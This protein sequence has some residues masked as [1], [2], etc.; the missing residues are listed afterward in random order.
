MPSIDWQ[1]AAAI[2]TVVSTLAI[3][4]S[5]VVVMLQLRQAARERYFSITAHLFEI[6][7][8]A[9]FQHDQLFLLHMLSCA[10]WDEF[11]RLGRG[12]RAEVAIHRVGGYYDR[13][14][15]LVRHDLIDKQDILPTIGGYAVAVWH[16]IEPLVKEMRLRENALL[17]ENYE[18]LLPE[19]HECYVP[20]IAPLTKMPGASVVEHP[21]PDH[22]VFD[23]SVLDHP[24]RDERILAR[25]N[26]DQTMQACPVKPAPAYAS[27]PREPSAALIQTSSV[28]IEATEGSKTEMAIWNSK[29]GGSWQTASDL[30]LPDS[31]GIAHALSE[32]T[33]S[34]T[35]VL[36]YARGAWCPFCL[37]QLSD[38]A[39]RYSEF[40]R[41]GVEVVALSPET[42]RKA[43]RMR[44]GL[45]LPFTVLSDVN[46]N[47]ARVFG[48]MDHEKP[49]VP[50]P[51]TLVLDS[52]GSVLL[53]TLNQGAKCLFAR[54]TLE[55][56]R[57]LKQG[58]SEA[59]ATLPAPELASPKP[60]RLF[61]Q[62][63]ANMA[64]GLFSR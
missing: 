47:A 49:G 34:G 54:D 12:E 41:S 29:G 30:S 46:F 42:P 26:G 39:E 61:A 64:A 60:G 15:N 48:L 21:V 7:Q 24:V 22:P 13:V 18:S 55:Y 38:Y 2:A 59:A 28:T 51:A 40:K 52:R 3:I 19:C 43:R 10:T 8:S 20:G 56:A 25:H 4:A 57:A 63:F 6:W 45:K 32:F 36:V 35:A 37:R 50:T 9:D 16:R 1:V 11:C 58:D 14:G 53:S 5:A 27:H 17:F 31:D 33:A 44:T 23:H 62:A